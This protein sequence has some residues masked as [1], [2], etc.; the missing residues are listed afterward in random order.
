MN[1]KDTEKYADWRSQTKEQDAYFSMF[2][3]FVSDLSR[4]LYTKKLIFCPENVMFLVVFQAERE[5]VCACQRANTRH[6]ELVK[7]SDQSASL[8]LFCWKIR[9]TEPS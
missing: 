2:F 5:V 6:S 4:F 9:S 7:S 3:C 8:G 1:P